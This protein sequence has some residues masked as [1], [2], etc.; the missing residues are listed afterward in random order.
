MRL[1]NAVC[2]LLLVACSGQ[3]EADQMTKY[4]DQICACKTAECA[5]KI[6]SEIEK[7][8][9]KNAGKEVEKKASDHYNAEIAGAQK[10]YDDLAAKK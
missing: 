5:D 10:C 4:A 6:I 3:Q 9:E 7:W 2:G 1:R 8:T